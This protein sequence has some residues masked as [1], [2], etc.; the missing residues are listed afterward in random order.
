MKTIRE[1]VEETF[2]TRKK[3]MKNKKSYFE[4][5]KFQMLIRHSIKK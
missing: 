3:K 5:V 4:G 2:W 1:N